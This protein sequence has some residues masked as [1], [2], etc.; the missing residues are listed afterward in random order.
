MNLFL[1]DD[2]QL[3]PQ[4]ASQALKIRQSSANATCRNVAG[5]QCPIT[6][7]ISFSP[8]ILG[9]S[10]PEHIFAMDP[11]SPRLLSHQF[12][13]IIKHPVDKQDRDRI[14]F[15]VLFFFS[16]KSSLQ[17]KK[18]KKFSLVV[19]FK[20]PDSVFPSFFKVID[21]KIYF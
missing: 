15:C 5:P 13:R 8:G 21:F 6:I 12:T 11:P 9:P 19:F 4:R 18:K 17:K 10:L 20:F 14:L 2:T 16:C 3:Q 1:W 7:S